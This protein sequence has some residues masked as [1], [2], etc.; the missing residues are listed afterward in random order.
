MRAATY[1]IVDILEVHGWCCCWKR[2]DCTDAQGNFYYV[3]GFSEI[4]TI[5]IWTCECLLSPGKSASTTLWQGNV[6]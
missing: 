1:G 3:N 5:T 2:D 6:V 4:Y